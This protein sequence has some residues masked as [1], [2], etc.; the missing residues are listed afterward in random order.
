MLITVLYIPP[1]KR[2]M[3]IGKLHGNLYKL[4]LPESS[5]QQ[6]MFPN[7]VSATSAILQSAFS[8]VQEVSNLWHDRLGHSH[9]NVLKH[10]DCLSSQICNKNDI[11]CDICQFAK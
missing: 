7:H 5:H 1:M 11:P 2:V 10:I 3:W 6:L 8:Q 9:V 4:I